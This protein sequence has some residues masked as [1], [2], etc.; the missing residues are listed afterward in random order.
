MGE[1]RLDNVGLSYKTDQGEEKI[2]SHMSITLGPNKLISIIGESG[3]GKSSLLNLLSGYLSPEEGEISLSCKINQVGFVFQNLYLIDHLNVIDNVSLPLVIYGEKK[4]EARKKALDAL[5][6]VGIAYLYKRKVDELSGGQKARVGIARSLVLDSQILLADEPTGSL[7]KE[8]SIS[9]MKIFKSLSKDRLV[10]LVTHNEKLAEEYS[11]EVYKIDNLTLKKVSDKKSSPSYE[12]E[13]NEVKHKSIRTKENI[14]LALSFLKKR[15]WK[16]FFSLLFTSFC[17]GMILTLLSFQKEGSEVITSLGKDYFDY[18]LVSM[19]ERKTYEIPGQE[20][21][22]SKS[23]MVSLNKQKEIEANYKTAAF[24]PSLDYFVPSYTQIQIEDDYFDNQVSVSPSFPLSEKLEA[25]RIPDSYDEVVVNSSFFKTNSLP[26]K[27]GTRFNISNDILVDTIIEEE[28][29]S[30]VV[31]LSF[32]FVVVGI[33]KEKDVLSRP[34]IYYSYHLMKDYLSSSYLEKASLY[35]ERD[36]LLKDRMEKY[37][38]EDDP[39]TGFKSICFVEDP[40][41]MKGIIEG[42][43]KSITLSSLPLQMTSSFTDIVSSFSKIVIIFMGLASLCSLLLELVV[44]E[45]L[46]QNKKEEMAVYLSFHISRKDFFRI[47]RGQVYIIG[48]MLF[49]LSSVFN[50]IIVKIINKVLLIYSLPAFLKYDLF[51]SSVLFLILISFTCAF[52]TS[53]IP[54]RG[55]YKSDLVLN[56]KG[57]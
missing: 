43:F 14:S 41:K 23:V 24:Y 28:K 45:N 6:K 19:S 37:S 53:E 9:I 20:M 36:F 26:Y 50:G 21:S 8:N 5:D 35:L 13:E 34:S 29:I 15:I 31:H 1:I 25:G 40:I 38:S 30:D 48:T 33:S 17:F 42:G 11:D 44:I 2:F 10:I 27:L 7:D 51:S 12:E 52:I 16:V 39:L 57:E 47:G 18:D 4:G 46:F 56:L 3:S 54:L 32:D 22:L 49:L 55:I